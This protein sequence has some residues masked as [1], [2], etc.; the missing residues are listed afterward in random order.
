MA[1]ADQILP[2][3]DQEL[4]STRKAIERVP[5]TKFSWKAHPKSNTMGWVANHLAEI[6]GWVEGTLTGTEWDFSPP[7]GPAYQ[8]PSLP[9]TAEV[10]AFF[11]ANVAQ[12][13]RAIQAVRD[14]Q[15]DVP[16]TLLYQGEKIFTM[17]RRDV[18]RSF[19]LNH[20]IHHR[21]ILTVY[22]RLNDLPVPGMYGP[23]GD[24]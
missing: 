14:D 12:A 7:G 23:S 15:L 6:P 17:P 16:W 19:V 1:Y 10:L 8:T 18:I 22:L 13:R 21:A 20:I 11:D 9:T 24:E 3:F 2:E 5:T 4:A